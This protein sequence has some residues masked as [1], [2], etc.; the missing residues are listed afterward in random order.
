MDLIDCFELA[1]KN[2]IVSVLKP[3]QEQ[4]DSESDYDSKKE[5]GGSF[6]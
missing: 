5:I 6:I 3:N 4:K 1:A 2:L